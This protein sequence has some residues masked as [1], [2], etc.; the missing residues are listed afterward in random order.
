MKTADTSTKTTCMFLAP[1]LFLLFAWRVPAAADSIPVGD[2]FNPKQ[3]DIEPAAGFHPGNETSGAVNRSLNPLLTDA[4]NEPHP[5][6][7]YMAKHDSRGEFPVFY[8]ELIELTPVNQVQSK[9]FDEVEFRKVKRI[10]IEVFENKTSAPN[11]DESAGRVVAGQVFRELRGFNNYKVTLSPAME[12]EGFRMRISTDLSKSAAIGMDKGTGDS[13]KAEPPAA[14]VYSK[15]ADA[16]LVGAV[17]KYLDTY[18]DNRGRTRKSLASGV[19]FG[20]FLIDARTGKVIWG[21]RYVGSQSPDIAGFFKSE[22]RWLDK[23]E[24]SRLAMKNVLR[25]FNQDKPASERAVP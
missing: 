19:E 10:H 20:A 4:I 12:E 25:A 1:L 16:I 21:S 15:D 6:P 18:V 14:S 23:E 3:A 9:I 17:T 11:R 5:F 2:A 13:Q 24:L 8:R 7:A 22:G